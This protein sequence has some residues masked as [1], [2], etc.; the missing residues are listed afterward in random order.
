MLRSIRENFELGMLVIEHDMTVIMR[1]AE[2]IQVLDH[3]KTIAVGTPA[4]IRQ[5]P[6]V[7]CAY[8]GT[9]DEATC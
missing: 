1:L 4:E 6:E 2:R 3:G 7:R 8:L 9:A 5:D